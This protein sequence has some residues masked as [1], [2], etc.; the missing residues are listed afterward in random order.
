ML[1][2]TRADVLLESSTLRHDES[3]TLDTD[4]LNTFLITTQY[5]VPPS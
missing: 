1:Y 5:A 2:V 3:E 4:A